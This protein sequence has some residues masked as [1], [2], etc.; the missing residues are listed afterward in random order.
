MWKI[1]HIVHALSQ[2]KEFG[3]KFQV[4][5]DF[6]EKLDEIENVLKVP[7]TATVDSQAIG[8]GLADFY[9]SWL[10]IQKGLARLID[11]SKY[12]NIAEKLTNRLREREPSLFDTPLMLCAVYLDPRINFKL[13]TG[14]KRNAAL[15]LIQIHERISALNNSNATNVMNDTLDEIQAEYRFGEGEQRDS[16]ITALLDS[17]AKF[18]TERPYDI[19]AT[20][21]DFWGKNGH[22]Y[23]VLEPL[24]QI[25]HAVAANQC[26]TER[27]FSSFTYIR[28]KH[29]MCMDVKNLSNLLMIRLNKDI[30]QNYRTNYVKQILDD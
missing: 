2:N 21:T 25:I 10:R 18:E 15:K 23:P 22:K 17:V 13:G 11:Q 28:S 26:G 27:S 20:V 1:K 6:W 7:Y 16:N 12:T 5:L 4:E 30:F 19:R 14:Q 8:Y 24:V 3:R 9:I 29:R